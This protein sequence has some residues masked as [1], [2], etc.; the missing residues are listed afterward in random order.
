MKAK[1]NSK[2]SVLA[3]SERRYVMNTQILSKSVKPMIRF[4]FILLAALVLSSCSSGDRAD[5]TSCSIGNRV[6]IDVTDARPREVFDQLSDQ[7]NC[8]ITFYPFFMRTVTVHM[9]NVRA[10]DVIVAVCQQLDAKWIYNVGGR[11][12]IMPLTAREKSNIQ[13]QEEWWKKFEIVLPQG[14]NFEEASVSSV[15]AEISAASG[16]EI[17]PWDG[18]GDQKVTLDISGMTVNE[19]LEAVVRQIDDSVGVVLVKSWDGHSTSQYRLVDK[20]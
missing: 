3:R 11:L 10:S 13:A 15:L 18:E 8:K 5:S 2:S 4:F 1:T 20:P 6:T 12:S 16:L 17:T 14:M 19:A 9:E 7:L